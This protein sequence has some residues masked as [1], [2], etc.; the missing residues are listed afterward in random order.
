MV[1]G[2]P[3]TGYHVVDLTMNMS[4]PL[5]TMLLAD[6][7]ATVIKIEPPAGDPIRKVGPGSRGLSA[8]FANLNRNKSSVVVDLKSEEGIE[9]VLDLVATADVFVQ[10]FRPGVAERL[11]LG[12]SDLC[13]QYPRLVYLAISG[14]GPTGPLRDAPAYDHVVQAMSGMAA[15]QAVGSE[16]A[17]L[18]RHGLVDKSTAYIAAQAIT[19][20]L[21]DR[22]RTGVGAVIDVSMLDVAIG[23]LWPDGMMEHTCESAE[24]DLPPIARSFRLTKTCDGLVSIVT[25]TDQQWSALA[26]A[27]DIK[28]DERAQSVEGRM[29]H[30]A[31]TMRAVARRLGEMTTEE[32][33]SRL[34]EAG[35]PCAPVIELSDVA[36]LPQVMA[37]D[38]LPVREHPVLGRIR[39]PR[40]AARW[41]GGIDRWEPA[42]TLG[43]HT[44]QVLAAP[45]RPGRDLPFG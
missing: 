31:E 14:Y 13:T 36:R 44:R 38:L 35:V 34:T 3:L 1:V 27:L 20:A 39:Q 19:A 29:R 32:V 12:A 22:H 15:R 18:V 4:G 8:Y 16:P 25:L 41:R 9:V 11:G 6:Q 30:G 43:E 23:F 5:A 42:P 21:L 26:S 7:G 37:N 45:Q 40:P 2:Q 33:V 24:I 10:N 17:S 28:A